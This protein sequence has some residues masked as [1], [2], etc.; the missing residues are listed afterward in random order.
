MKTK[1]SNIKEKF[2]YFK[3]V[4]LNKIEKHHDNNVN[5]DSKNNNFTIIF[6]HGTNHSCLKYNYTYE[7]DG[8]TKK[9]YFLNKLSDISNLFLY[10][11]PEEILRFNYEEGKSNNNVEYP[12]FT[13]NTHIV[14]L[15]EFLK[16]EKIK[17]P[18]V[19]VSHSIGSL[20]ALK[21]AQKYSK[22]IKHVFLIDPIQF[23]KKVA[24][25]FY[26]HPISNS[27]L[28]KHIEIVKN[29]KSS[30]KKVEKSLSILDLN[31]YSIPY[32]TPNIKSPL[33]TFF[34]VDTKSNIHNKLTVPYIEELKKF[35]SLFS[36]YYYF[37]RDHYLNETNPQG[38]ITKIKKELRV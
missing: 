20:Y 3:R 27:E 6:F 7:T 25:N 28:K 36:N 9:N 10:N 32:F 14:N 5:N 33:T 4:K 18:Y 17:P 21:F 37:D 30:K 11:R 12:N 29:S 1:H 16:H 34:N 31:T 19:L 35:N 2:N 38:L 26:N 24:Q 13:I 22:D 23:T 15:Y 8:T